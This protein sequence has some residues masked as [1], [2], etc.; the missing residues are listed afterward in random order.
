MSSRSDTIREIIAPSAGVPAPMSRCP[1]RSIREARWLGAANRSTRS[2]SILSAAAIDDSSRCRLC[3]S[4]GR[5]N[6]IAMSRSLEARERPAARDPKMTSTD[7]RPAR[8]SSRSNTCESAA[9]IR[10]SSSDEYSPLIRSNL[11]HTS[12]PGQQTSSAATKVPFFQQCANIAP[13]PGEEQLL[14]LTFCH[15]ARPHRIAIYEKQS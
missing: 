9:G 15:V 8:P 5:S 12:R 7:G 2:T 13:G 11:A 10:R 1:C 3:A 6:A 14:F 4:T